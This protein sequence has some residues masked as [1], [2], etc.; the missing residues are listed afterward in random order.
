MIRVRA[1]LSV[2]RNVMDIVT[3]HRVVGVR[4]CVSVTVTINANVRGRI[5]VRTNITISINVI[6]IVSGRTTTIISVE[7][8]PT[9]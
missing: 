2:R 1:R 9:P 5:R 4:V 6:T 8:A 7:S 3:V